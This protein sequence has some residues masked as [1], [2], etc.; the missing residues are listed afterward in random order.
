MWYVLRN[1]LE[2]FVVRVIRNE[3]HVRNLLRLMKKCQKKKTTLQEFANCIMI[4]GHCF[5]H[6]VDEIQKQQYQ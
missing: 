3:M 5:N 6:Y 4:I 2:T 1:V